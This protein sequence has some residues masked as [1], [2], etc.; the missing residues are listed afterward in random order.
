MQVQKQNKTQCHLEF[1]AALNLCMILYNNQ[2]VS[3]YNISVTKKVR[4]RL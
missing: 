4:F 2:G 1:R 3:F